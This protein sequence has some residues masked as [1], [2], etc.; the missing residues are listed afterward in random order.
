MAEAGE[1]TRDNIGVL[2]AEGGSRGHV[3]NLGWH[4]CAYVT[5]GDAL[6]NSQAFSWAL[7]AAAVTM[8]G[9]G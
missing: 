3:G 6:A 5:S 2:G 9:S 1:D 4:L 8:W 7:G